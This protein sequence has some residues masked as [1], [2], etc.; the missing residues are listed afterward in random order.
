MAHPTWGGISILGDKTSG[1]TIG[2]DVVSALV[3]GD[4]VLC[5]L[6]LDPASG[7]VSFAKTF[8][9]S[10]IGTIT[11]EQDL[12]NGSGASGVRIAV[13]WAFVTGAGTCALTATHPTATAKTIGICKVSGCDGTAPIFDSDSSTSAAPGLTPPANDVLAISFVGLEGVGAAQVNTLT[14]QTGFSAEAASTTTFGTSG[15]SGA[16]NISVGYASWSKDPANT[17]NVVPSATVVT[18]TKVW[19]GLIFQAPVATSKSPP[20]DARDRRIRRNSLLRR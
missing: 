20:L 17:S 15:G 18:G 14:G 3:V 19:A 12:A 13:A 9:T 6:C 2:S 8:G 1:T 7:T 11:V 5:V 4:V 16:S 10:T